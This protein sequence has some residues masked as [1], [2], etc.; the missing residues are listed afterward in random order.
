M[1]AL[2]WLAEDID[3]R[4]FQEAMHTCD[5]TSTVFNKKI[6]DPQNHPYIQQDVPGCIYFQL[7]PTEA[8]LVLNHNADTF[9]EGILI[10]M[11]Q[12]T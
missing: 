9:C 1:F 5:V 6:S 2:Y 11:Q 7:D 12:L 8:N 3:F 10:P 4:T